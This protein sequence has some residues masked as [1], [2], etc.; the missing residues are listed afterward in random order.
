MAVAY[1]NPQ[2]AFPEPLCTIYEP[3]MKSQLLKRFEIGRHSLRRALE[4]ADIQLLP[5]S[6]GFTLADVNDPDGY[7]QAVEFFSNAYPPL[8]LPRGEKE[9]PCQNEENPSWEG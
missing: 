9:T 4:Q 8:P 3:G 7:G 1:Q 2:Y 6:N 5:A